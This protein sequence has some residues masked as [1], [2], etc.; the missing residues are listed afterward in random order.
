MLLWVLL[1]VVAGV[2]AVGVLQNAQVVGVSFLFWQ[3]EASLALTILGATA[4][5]LLIGVLVRWVNALGRWR[6]RSAAPTP[7]F[8]SLGTRIGR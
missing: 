6:A 5:G 3:F 8:A 2:V 4:A 1:A 7:K